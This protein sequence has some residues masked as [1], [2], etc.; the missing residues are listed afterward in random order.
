MYDP[1]K[2]VTKVGGREYLEVK[3]RILWFRDQHPGGSILTEVVMSDPLLVRATITNGDGHVLGTGHGSAN[4]GGKKVVWTGREFEKAETAAVGRALAHAGYGTQFA[5]ELDED[6][7][8]ADS[9]VEPQTK[10]KPQTPAQK[11]NRDEVLDALAP[12]FSDPDAAGKAIDQAA[13]PGFTTPIVALAAVL[14]MVEAEYSVK[15]EP[16]AK[17]LKVK[18]L[19]ELMAFD[20]WR[21]HLREIVAVAKITAAVRS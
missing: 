15:P 19:S 18:K 7:H 20:N 10:P 12:F 3:F 5:I 16:I 1:K 2:N 11:W 6:D 14:A 21:N 9:P 13:R 17:E 8:L 4:A